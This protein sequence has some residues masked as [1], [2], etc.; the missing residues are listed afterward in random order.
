MSEQENALES[1]S[2]EIEGEVIQ[3]GQKVELTAIPIKTKAGRTVE[4][5]LT[6]KFLGVQRH[7]DFDH[8]MVETKP[9]T[10]PGSMLVDAIAK[11]VL[12]KK[13]E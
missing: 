4:S 1:G 13:G 5:K 11:V 2:V 6:G 12:V 9:G 7:G 10:L 3:P 8:V